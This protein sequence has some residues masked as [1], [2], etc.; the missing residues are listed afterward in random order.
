MSSFPFYSSQVREALAE[1][2]SNHHEDQVDRPA[3]SA[4]ASASSSSAP[5]SHHASL[6]TGT[7]IRGKWIGYE[8]SSS[9]D[10]DGEKN[11]AG[12]DDDSTSSSS[13]SSMEAIVEENEESI[14]TTN[15]LT[16]IA[17]TQQQRQGKGLSNSKQIKRSKNKKSKDDILQKMGKAPSILLPVEEVGVTNNT[18]N[19]T[20]RQ[21]KST[22]KKALEIPNILLPINYLRDNPNWKVSSVA[23][24]LLSTWDQL[25]GSPSSSSSSSSP[26]TILMVLLQ[27]GRFAAAVFSLQSSN[28]SNNN[29]S[30]RTMK[31]LAHKTSTRYTVRKGQGGSQS[32]YDQ[33]KH[34]AKSV[35]AQLRREGEKQLREDVRE[36][37]REWKKMGHVRN[38]LWVYVS[39]PKGMRRDYLFGGG[40]DAASSNN[41]ALVDKN[42][43][44]L[45]NIPLDV[46]RPTMEATAAVLDCVLRCSVRDMTE[47]EQKAMR[48]DAGIE[49]EVNEKEKGNE[50]KKEKEME[51][52]EENLED[53]VTPE[54]PAPPLTPLHQAVL[55]GDL[56]RLM[57]L[58]KLLDES[59]EQNAT[60]INNADQQ[61]SSSI[62]YDVNTTG[63]SEHQ[64]PLH[65]AS[66]SDHPNA[67]SL[68]NALLVQGHANPCVIDARGRPPYFLASSDKHRE[69][70][71]LARGTLGEDY[72]PWDEGAKVGPA[73]TNTD[74]QLKKSKALEKKRRQRARQ[75]EKKANE[76]AAADKAAAQKREEEERT[77]REEDAKRIR[78]RLKPKTSGASNVCDFCQKVVKG[79]RRSQMFQRLEYAYCSTEC[80]KRHQ[81]EL[82][83]AAATARLG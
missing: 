78:D 49:L 73:L 37:W 15:S 29:N 45:R 77:K 2:I 40:E 53:S 31:M 10:D 61:T 6:P 36:A 20:S 23:N 69:V 1:I 18:K 26:P 76:K 17:A 60:E 83:A 12:S 55:D 33:S 34:K 14:T 21:N 58:L 13:T 27:S 57:E 9:D 80:V 11:A 74:V 28:G 8:S 62:D 25:N 70:F 65:I 82:M 68:L 66:S 71:R 44:R 22:R 7:A 39:V 43:E 46:G 5:K 72:F 56:S 81:R 47:G 32:N 35:G 3:S 64:T 59:E 41:N 54:A 52:E 67:T 79:K 42:D 19:G 75:K 51:I 48:L 16:A 4:E 30:T 63:G 38:A 50:T 24:S